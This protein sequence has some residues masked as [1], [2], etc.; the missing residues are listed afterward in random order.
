[1]KLK[2]KVAAFLEKPNYVPIAFCGLIVVGGTLIGAYFWHESKADDVPNGYV[3]E[4]N[5]NL[6]SD[7]S[8]ASTN[9]SNAEAVADAKAKELAESDEPVMM[10]K[11]NPLDNPLVDENFTMTEDEWDYLKN[12]VHGLVLNYSF[13]EANELLNN[14]VTGLDLTKVEFG[15]DIEETHI[16][17]NSL[18]FIETTYG[19]NLSDDDVQA[20][21]NILISQDTPERALIGALWISLNAKVQVILN[22]ESLVPMTESKPTIDK[23][24][25]LEDIHYLR[26]IN[27]SYKDVEAIQIDFTIDNFPLYAIVLKKSDGTHRV[28]KIYQDSDGKA[29]YQ[30]VKYWKQYLKYVSPAG[31]P[32]N[33]GGGVEVDD[34][35]EGDKGYIDD[36]DDADHQKHLKAQGG[37]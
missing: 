17:I 4:N 10:N 23:V 33:V 31:S 18:A 28:W 5:T 14:R 35:N 32:D 37:K 29:Y 16:D 3:L 9:V 36:N 19:N 11:D 13:N 2:E 12:Q 21:Y 1:M 15:E 8:K 24:A 25:P 30:N 6:G 7:S 27:N 26:T 20:V 34:S 22:Q